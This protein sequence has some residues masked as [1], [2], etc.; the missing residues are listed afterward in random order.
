MSKDCLV[1]VLC[2]AYN[3][4]EY[5]RDALESIVTQQTDFPFELLVNDD[6]STDGTA[7]IIREYAE[8]YPDIVRPFYQE[9]NLYSQD[10]DIY[11]A[12]FF[13]NARGKYVAFCE[14]T[15]TGQ[16][17]PSSSVRSIFSKRT[18]SIPPASTTRSCTT[19]PAAA[20]TKSSCSAAGTAMLSLRIFSPA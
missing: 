15:I 12:V 7:A 4:E 13:P 2:T 11:Y 3:H 19:A 18:R 20:R 6:A 1:S 17:P 8:K 5:I 9:K 14:G 10:I 16:T